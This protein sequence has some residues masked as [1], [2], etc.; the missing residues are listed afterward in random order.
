M[1]GP[2]YH[3]DASSGGQV[4]TIGST[5]AFLIASCVL[6]AT[7]YAL[8]MDWLGSSILGLPWGIWLIAGAMA[9][10]WSVRSRWAVRRF[11]PEPECRPQEAV[12]S[13]ADGQ[14][15]LTFSDVGKLSE[16]G[17]DTLGSITWEVPRFA[18]RGTGGTAVLEAA[19]VMARTFESATERFGVRPSLP[20][21]VA[22]A[23]DRISWPTAPL[24]VGVSLPSGF[25]DAVAGAPSVFPVEWIPLRVE[26][27]DDR[28]FSRH[29]LDAI[30]RLDDLS[31]L[32]VSTNERPGREAAWYDWSA[33]A[34]LAYASVFPLRVDPAQ[35]SLGAMKSLR[36]PEA[37]LIRALIDASAVLARSAPRLG[38]A[39]RL[40]GRRP[41]SVAERPTL[42]DRA[43]LVLSQRVASSA[44]A[45]SQLY[46]SA[47]RA[48][49]A[50]LATTEADV[51]VEAR[52]EGIEAAW[53][54]IPNEPHVALRAVAVRVAAYEDAGAMEAARIAAELID[55]QDAT[56]GPEPWAFIQSELEHSTP[57]D[58]TLGRIAAGVCLICATAPA[59]DRDFLMGD[60]SDDLR[61]T[62]WLIG[63]EDD[64]R[65]LM[66]LM[67]TVLPAG[68]RAA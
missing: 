63:R 26:D 50:W 20:G 34:P 5:P 56:I 53:R 49:S 40:V 29:H 38:L 15:M 59:G 46:R 4:V 24:R 44:S 21:L 19:M 68:A 12:R 27:R 42:A 25:L 55:P 36:A 14:L 23:H 11:E 18:E 57:G 37:G 7:G 48:V 17:R 45:D 67:R 13:G 31:H 35:I 51:P 64:Q 61:H 65:L 33:P 8:G 22:S 2:M 43:M 47:A 3:H 32:Y 30:V 66:E 9:V 1:T 28:A 54:A 6:V 58:M 62:G 16:S 60:L 10:R 39:D 41:F 52:S